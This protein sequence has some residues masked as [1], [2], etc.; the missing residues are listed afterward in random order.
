M[1][2]SDMD[3]LRQIQQRTDAPSAAGYP[4]IPCVDVPAKIARSLGSFIDSYQPHNSV[5]AYR[6]VITT[7]GRQALQTA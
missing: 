3:W 6:W 2:R 7:R 5:H 1:A 4:G